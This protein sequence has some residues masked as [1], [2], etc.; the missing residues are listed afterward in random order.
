MRRHQRV[1]ITLFVSLFTL[2]TLVGCGTKRRRNLYGGIDPF[3]NSNVGNNSVINNSPTVP[4]TSPQPILRLE[5]NPGSS[6]TVGQSISLFATYGNETRFDFSFVGIP[7]QG[8]SMLTDRLGVSRVDIIS[9]RS[10]PVFEVQVNRSGYASQPQR[11]QL[12]FTEAPNSNLLLDSL[13]NI[14][15]PFAHSG[16]NIPRV[17]SA[18]IFGVSGENNDFAR[19]TR[20]WTHDPTETASYYY[21]ENNF[22]LVFK[23]AGPKT[24]YF[25]A[26]VISYNNSWYRTS[27]T[28]RGQ[29]T[30][31]VAPRQVYE[32]RD[33]CG[34]NYVPYNSYDS[35]CMQWGWKN[36]YFVYNNACVAISTPRC[37]TGNYYRGAFDDLAACEA[38]LSN[39]TCGN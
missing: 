2:S 11:I 21:S 17:G 5:A 3:G 27:S 19:V 33:T 14:Q 1:F 30:V 8:V 6:V 24:I 18:S 35:T 29:T 34:I 4:A 36:T 37:S 31:Q 16:E 15:G 9:N 25:E 12:Q 28:C 26:E 20:V 32:L 13:C 23:S 7:P 22:Y 10:T 39:G 38:S